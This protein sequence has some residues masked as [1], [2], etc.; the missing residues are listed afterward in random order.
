MDGRV[1][2]RGVA[3]REAAAELACGW[4]R[5]V[6]APALEHLNNLQ[7]H[8]LVLAQVCSLIRLFMTPL[9]SRSESILSAAIS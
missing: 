3:I 4:P 2:A 6:L 1:P 8:F 5:A 7:D 9:I